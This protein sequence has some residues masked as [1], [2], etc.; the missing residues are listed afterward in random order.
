[1]GGQFPPSFAQA[2]APAAEFAVPTAGDLDHRFFQPKQVPFFIGHSAFEATILNII[3]PMDAYM[4]YMV[5]SCIF[6]NS[7]KTVPLKMQIVKLRESSRERRK[8]KVGATSTFE[9]L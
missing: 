9:V 2:G 5:S 8:D 3:L 1:M 4:R 6:M 7:F